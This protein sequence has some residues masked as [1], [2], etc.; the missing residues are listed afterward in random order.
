MRHAGPQALD[1]LEPLLAR[2]RTAPG[3]REKGRGVFYAGARAALHFHEDPAGLF[4]DVRPSGAA[5][6]ERIDVTGEA[7]KEHLLRRLGLGETGE[8]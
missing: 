3:L 5:D 8:A 4:A 1:A 7:G 2:L 6:F